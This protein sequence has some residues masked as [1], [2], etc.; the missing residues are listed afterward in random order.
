LELLTED[1]I[2]HF[3]DI[4]T[5]DNEYVLFGCGYVLESFWGYISTHKIKYIIDSNPD[6]QNQTKN[7]IK[8]YS[9]AHYFEHDRGTKVIV[10][11][12]VMSIIDFLTES[13]LQEDIE[14]TTIFRFYQ[15]NCFSKSILAVFEACIMANTVCT[16][17]CYSCSNNIPSF[18]KG[19]I[20]STQEIIEDIDTYFAIVDRTI[21]FRIAGGEPLLHPELS[22][23]L[24][25]IGKF[26]RDK[27]NTVE[28][29]TNGTL[30]PSL[31]VIT[32][33]KEYEISFFISDYSAV[34]SQKYPI[35]D[36]EAILKQHQ[37]STYRNVCYQNDNSWS[38]LGNPNIIQSLSNEQLRQR[39]TYC[40]SGYLGWCRHVY[41]NR[42]Y[43]C[44]TGVSMNM[45]GIGHFVES[46]SVALNS[47]F[48]AQ[49]LK[50]LSFDLGYI[51]N[52]YLSTCQRCDGFGGTNDK[53][54]NAGTQIHP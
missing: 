10:S 35:E 6:L 44:G 27:C 46:D 52:G 9:P 28:V 3:C 8:I 38:N 54:V 14:F 41:K 43:Y 40:K 51:P 49:K 31:S 15:I 37:V 16:L 32:A 48:Y 26:Y 2:N 19:T 18:Q 50:I 20:R 12:G 21:L 5:P 29:V 45:A 39:F 53:F 42:F 25:H 47:S 33:C 1:S 7:G 36:V 22:K 11:A 13:G 24:N 4:W 17:K 30:V 34:I 23:I